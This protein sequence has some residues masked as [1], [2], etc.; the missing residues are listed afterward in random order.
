MMVRLTQ[1]LRIIIY[2]NRIIKN[3]HAITSV[4][5]LVNSWLKKQNNQKKT[6]Q[7]KKT[8]NATLTENPVIQ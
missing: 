1:R 7:S 3:L 4:L 6:K 2:K 8:T 5:I